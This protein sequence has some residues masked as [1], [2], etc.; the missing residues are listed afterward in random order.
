MS[1]NLQQFSYD[2]KSATSRVM[3]LKW[4]SKSVAPLRISNSDPCVSIISA[5]YFLMSVL[6]FSISVFRV[7]L[8]SFCFA[9]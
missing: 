1:D 8:L 7:M 9:M 5:W 4:C 3:N 6:V 2:S